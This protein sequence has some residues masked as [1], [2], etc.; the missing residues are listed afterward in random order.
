MA[1]DQLICVA[2]SAELGDNFHSLL[3]CEVTIDPK[4]VHPEDAASIKE[5]LK[6]TEIL[7]ISAVPDHH[8]SEVDALFGEDLLLVKPPF[9]FG[10]GMSCDG[11]SCFSV[12]LCTC[13]KDS[14]NVGGETWFVGRAFDDPSLDSGIG[15]TVNDVLDKVRSEGVNVVRG[16]SPVVVGEFV[17]CVQA[18]STDDVEINSVRH[19]LDSRDITA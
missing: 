3:C 6:V 16:A 4:S 14:L 13:A 5:L 18:C 7:G 9:Q 10:V 12:G 2:S 11:A 15:E 17:E 19:G 8:P 1:Q